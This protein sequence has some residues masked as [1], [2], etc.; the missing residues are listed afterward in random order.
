MDTI[1]WIVVGFTVGWIA[2]GISLVRNGKSSSVFLPCFLKQDWR[3]SPRARVPGHFEHYLQVNKH[4]KIVLVDSDHP[5]YKGWYIN[6]VIGEHH[7][8]GND[9]DDK[10]EP[11]ATLEAAKELA[12]TYIPWCE[13][14]TE[15][16][17]PETQHEST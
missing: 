12:V 13:A 5:Q 6:V 4:C 14:K 1:I 3:K 15:E 2:R 7:F 9:V 17:F 11:P 8:K 10:F 16:L